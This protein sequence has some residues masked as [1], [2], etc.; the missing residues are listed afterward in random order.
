MR[1]SRQLQKPQGSELEFTA[2]DRLL[3]SDPQPLLVGGQAVN[4]WAEVFLQNSP[5]LERLQPFLSRDCDLF[6]NQDL[7]VRLARDTHWKAAF[8]PG[9]QA[10]PVVGYLVHTAADGRNLLAEVLHSVKGLAPA[11]LQKEVLV[12][13]GNKRYKTLSPIALLK[14][15][16]ANIIELPQEGPGQERNDLKHVRILLLCVSAY[17]GQALQRVECG[18]STERSFLNLLEETLRIARSDY[19]TRVA[20]SEGLNFAG[21]FPDS[22]GTSRLS[23]VQNFVR[24][25]LNS[26]GATRSGG[27]C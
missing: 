23:K 8:S 26:R 9:G 4:L 7:L 3:Q 27:R 15:K 24:N 20:R 22:L 10:S 6:G 12:E 14:A 1:L 19:A 21:C 18:T 13:L 11:D 2:F 16:L 5:E 17:L 25:R